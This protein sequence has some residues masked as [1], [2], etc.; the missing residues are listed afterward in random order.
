MDTICLQAGY[1]RTDITPSYPIPLGGYGDAPE[2]FHDHV[3]DPICA[4]CVAISDD[5]NT[6]LLYHLDLLYLPSELADRCRKALSQRHGI[7]E[8]NIL[9]NCT[10]THSAPE[11][12]CDLPPTLRYI[13]ELF[14]AILDLAEPALADL[15]PATVSIG[16][17]Q[18]LGWNFSRRY[19]L[20]D[21]SY[22]GDNFGDFK[23][24]TILGHETEADHDMQAV[25]FSREGKKD[26][27]L[28]N[29]QGHP[30]LVGNA[31]DFALS[32]DVF[33]RLRDMAEQEHD[34]HFAFFQ[35]CEGN[36]NSTSRIKSECRS[37]DYIEVAR[38]LADGLAQVMKTMRPVRSGPVRATQRIFSAPVNHSLDHLVEEAAQ[39]VAFRETHN[40]AETWRLAR[41]LGFNSLY[42]ARAV[43]R[44]SRMP[45]TLEYAIGAVSFGDVCIVWTPNE[46]F[47]TVG[48]FLKE[49]LPFEMSFVCSCTNGSRAYMPTIRAFHH[50][51]Y[52]CDVCNYVPGTT[53]KLTWELMELGCEVR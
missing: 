36:L 22:G 16:S 27:L 3:L 53:E 4:A 47:D 19:L 31:D 12:N 23:N 7:P 52:G 28:V 44:R 5:T 38:G 17:G 51:G 11:L 49:T 1:A 48:K 10:H 46:L 20:S 41:S 21:G 15:A 40:H 24:N 33:G 26:I 43:V 8:K 9:L 25:R 45:E 32:C 6:T 29:W 2:R 42:H 13:E 39:V 34:V 18:V 35:G 37:T 50:G 14:Q 30:Q